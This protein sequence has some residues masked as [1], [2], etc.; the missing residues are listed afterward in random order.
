[1]MIQIHKYFGNRPRETVQRKYLELKQCTE[2]VY[3]LLHKIYDSFRVHI[4]ATA[5][6]LL[7]LPSLAVLA[8]EVLVLFDV[9]GFETDTEEM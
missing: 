7:P 3:C 8:V 4:T 5:T 1:M 9:G 2:C 6:G